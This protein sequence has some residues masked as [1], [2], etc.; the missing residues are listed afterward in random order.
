[1]EKIELFKIDT[2]ICVVRSL[3]IIDIKTRCTDFEGSLPEYQIYLCLPAAA[4][5]GAQK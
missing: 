3:H 2:L 1:M 5:L 4:W